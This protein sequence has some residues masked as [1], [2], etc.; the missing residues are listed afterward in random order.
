MNNSAS[1]LNRSTPRGKSL[2]QVYG[3]IDDLEEKFLGVDVSLNQDVITFKTHDREYNIHKRMRVPFV[4]MVYME[5]NIKHRM[6]LLQKTKVKVTEEQGMAIWD[7]L[8]QEGWR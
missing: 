2:M 3:E 7:K 8:Q 4:K 5:R 6:T 1:I